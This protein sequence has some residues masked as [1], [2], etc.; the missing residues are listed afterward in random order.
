MCDRKLTRRELLRLG[1]G[2]GVAFTVLGLGACSQ[3][4]PAAAPTSGPAATPA[5]AAKSAEIT[6]WP[7]NPS[8]SSIV[9]EK[10]LPIAKKTYPEL[11]VKLEPPAENNDQK[12]LVAYAGGTAPD[13]AVTMLHS[14]HAFY[15]KKM[16][17]SIQTYVDGDPDV[18]GLLP[19]YVPSAI[20]GYTYQGKLHAVPT[21]NESVLLFYNK[22][23]IV[24][25]G[26]KPPREIEDDPKQWNWDTLV[27]YAKA[28]NKGTGFRRERFGIIVTAAKAVNS[29]TQAWGNLAYA[30][31]GRF[32]DED[33]EKWLFT[34]AE[35][36][37]AV[38]WIA[39]LMHKHDVHPDVGEYTSAG[40]QDRGLFQNGQMGFVVQGEYFRRYLWGTGKPSGGIPFAYDMALMPYCPATGKRTNVYHGCGSFMTSQTKDADATWKWLKTIFGKESQAIFTEFWGSRGAHKGTYGP[41]LE[42]NAGGGPPGLNYQAIV[43][44]DAD[45]HPHPTTPYLTHAA[46]LEPTT[47]ILYDNVFLKK[48]SV[49]EGLSQIDKETK[50]LLEKGKKESQ[51]QK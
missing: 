26:L 22:D 46:L 19:E 15:G 49:Q 13:S 30:R 16:L 51:A 33:G 35:A 4:T 8:E 7:R 41:W 9:W 28:V 44:A 27:T 6:F 48:M 42:S 18:K 50:E 31:G 20:K 11:V 32:L 5:P 36:T 14:L 47:R 43:K 29:L 21:V 10:V 2:S 23:A 37:E 12:L 17:K 45:V 38:Q 24:Q 39:D 25:A 34:G 1:A 3:P 40:I